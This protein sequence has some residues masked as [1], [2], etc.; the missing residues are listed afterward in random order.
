MG[1]LVSVVIPAYNAG[2]F[3]AETLESVFAQT[4]EPLEVI[5]V[6]DGSTD[7]T[8]DIARRFPVNLLSGSNGGRSVAR[9]RGVEASAGQLIAF[10]DADDVW[11]PTRVERQVELLGENPDVDIASCLIEVFVEPGIDPP[12]WLRPVDLETRRGM[13]PSA[14][15]VR[16][17]L[18]R[19]VGLFDPQ[20]VISQDADWIARALGSGAS[21]GFVEEALV[22]YRIHDQNSVHDRRLV[23]TE[24]FRVLRSAAARARERGD[25]QLD[26]V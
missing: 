8:A 6:D 2:R 9:N 16:R 14:L 18:L 12:S 20:Y 22:R 17:S 13:Q 10:C 21:M 5:V 11:L 4:H 15:L 19:R 25:S 3:L 1:E 23:W 7:A 26:N 24:T